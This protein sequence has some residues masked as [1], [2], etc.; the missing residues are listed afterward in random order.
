MSAE[1]EKRSIEALEAASDEELAVL[2]RESVD[3]EAVLLT[4]Y[5]KVIRYHAGRFA[6]SQSDIDDL[7]QEGLIVLLRAISEFRQER[8][9]KFSTFAH[10]CILNR[11]KNV[12]RR[13][14]HGAVSAEEAVLSLEDCIDLVDPDTP[15]SILLEKENFAQCRM[16]VMAMLSGRE[17]EILQCIMT[18]DSYQQT[19]EKLGI[20]EKS[21][22]NAMQR[23]RRKM[24]TVESTSYF[25]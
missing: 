10:T 14:Q 20:S 13:E 21:V 15:E 8:Q 11:M 5:L 1:A 18:G 19:A 3:A 25:Q 23:V 12:V 6:R 17:W 7:A 22:D 2:A 4:R 9:V 24:R 16:Q